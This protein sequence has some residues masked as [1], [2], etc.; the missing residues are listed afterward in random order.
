M[1]RCLILC[2]TMIAAPVAAADRH[3]P[4]SWGKAGVPFDR[5]RTDAV[6]CATSGYFTDVRGNPS[7]DMF[8]RG[9]NVVDRTLNGSGG[10]GDIMNQRR[11]FALDRKI[12][13]V[14]QHLHAIVADCLVGKGYTRFRLTSAQA[15]AVGKLEKGSDGR[16]RYLH[17]LGSDGTIIERQKL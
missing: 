2:A 16:K 7:A 10:G 13:E 12:D 3:L 14:D 15:R 1:I 5:Y 11:L 9:F 4:V 8:V 17:Q 6:E